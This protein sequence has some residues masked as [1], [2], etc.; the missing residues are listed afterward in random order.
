MPWR[1]LLLGLGLALVVS[2][3][4]GLDGGASPA[5]AAACLPKFA[6]ARLQRPSV[7][8]PDTRATST[9]RP[10]QTP[11]P[12]H[13]PGPWVPSTPTVTATA[14]PAAG[15]QAASCWEVTTVESPDDRIE[16]TS[17]VYPGGSQHRLLSFQ[18]STSGWSGSDLDYRQERIAF[19]DEDGIKVADLRASG[20]QLLVSQK[21][22]LALL[23]SRGADWSPYEVEWDPDEQAVLV[24]LYRDIVGGFELL[25]VPLKGSPTYVPY[26]GRA[27]SRSER[28][29]SDFI[30]LDTRTWIDIAGMRV[31]PSP[32]THERSVSLERAKQSGKATVMLPPGFH[33]LRDL[34]RS[35]DGPLVWVLG[36]DRY[37]IPGNRAQVVAVDRLTGEVRPITPLLPAGVHVERVERLP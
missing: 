21:A 4:L 31:F 16:V 20:V 12:T 27:S 8:V 10:A 30:G 34:T 35:K 11:L 29:M 14:A 36:T 22:L 23:P 5:D 13:T 3:A 9:P 6:E 19:A 25:R 18:R 15:P 1:W 26:E 24:R 37:P 32:L 17:R 33:H 28:M 2:A 7:W